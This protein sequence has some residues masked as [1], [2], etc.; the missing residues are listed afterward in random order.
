MIPA[1]LPA[2]L[3]L[4]Y[5]TGA[6]HFAAGLA[7]LFAVLPRLAA[8][9]EACMISLFVLLIHI[10]A[11]IREPASRLQ[12]TMVFIA[13]ALAGAVWIISASLRETTW[14]WSRR[15]VEHHTLRVVRP[16]GQI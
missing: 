4:A 16:P 5:L 7:I 2:H 13:T 6:C 14:G 10:P 12:W 15:S 11:A 8:T 1:W 9:M 3:G